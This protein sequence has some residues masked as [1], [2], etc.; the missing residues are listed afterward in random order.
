MN[1]TPEQWARL[2]RL[3]DEA[4]QLSLQSRM[5]FL[6]RVRTEKGE[7]MAEQL[8]ALLKAHDEQ[9]T[10]ADRPLVRP[11]PP[12][13]S[14][15]VKVG[16]VVLKSWLQRHSEMIETK[17]SHYHIVE[18][19]GSGGMGVVYKARD[20]RLDRFVALKFLPDDVALG[21]EVLERF[22]REARAASALNHPNICT[23]Y[24]IGEEGGRAF[25]VMEFLDGTTLKQLIDG[26]PLEVDA[27][28]RIASGLADA[29]D[30]AHSHRIIHRDIKPANIFVTGRGQAKILD[31][32]LAKLRAERALDSR[33]TTLGIDSTQSIA[34]DDGLTVAG[35]IMGTPAYMSP[36]QAC[37]EDVDARS[38]LFS[39]GAVLYEMAT[40]VRSFDGENSGAILRAVLHKDPVSPSQLNPKLPAGLDEII[41]K[42][43]AK[44]RDR[45]YTTAA[46]MEADLDRLRQTGGRLAQSAEKETPRDKRRRWTLA[47]ATVA[48]L[49]LGAAGWLYHPRPAHALSDTDTVVLADFTNSTGESV[50]DPTLQQVLETSL[51]QSPFLSVLPSQAVK[52]TLKRMG[53]PPGEQLTTDVVKEVGQRAGSKAFLAGSIARLDSQYVIVLKAVNCQT[54]ETLA[55]TRETA[56]RK[57]D[58]IV[59][60]QN[61]AKELREKLGESLASIQKVDVA[62]R[63]QQ[64]TT[65]SLEAWQSYSAARKAGFKAAASIPLYQHA[66]ELD[67][68][69]AMAHLSLGLTYL[70]LGEPDRAMESIKKAYELRSRV[71]EWE[72]YAIEGRYHASVTGDLEKARAVYEAWGATYPRRAWLNNI[73]IIDAQLG[74]YQKAVT[75]LHTVDQHIMENAN[76]A[77]NLGC[78]LA[79]SYM[80]LGLLKDARSKSEENLR[81]R[82]NSSCDHET[83]YLIA[84][85]ENDSVGMAQQ[86]AWASQ[87]GVEDFPILEEISAAYSGRLQKARE[88]SRARVAAAQAQGRPE[89]AATATAEASLREA[90]FG[91]R[92]EALQL[93]QDAL[94]L[95]RG[96]ITEYLAAVIFALEGGWEKAQ[97]LADDL[98][99]R[100]PED[101]IVRFNYLPS[102][103]A[104]IELDRRSPTNALRELETTRSYELGQAPP[105]LWPV[106]V[107]G[108]AY[109]AAHQGAEAAVE[110]QKI[111]DHRGM[112]N[113]APAGGP[114]DALAHLGLARAYS[115]QGDTAK[116]RGAYQDFFE[117]WKNADTNIRVLKEAR[118]EFNKL[119]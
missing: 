74:E 95:A 108:Q 52:A 82:P 1:P 75:L 59:A 104:L 23:I 19:L 14:S 77:A 43:L 49:I 66:I 107:R 89:T 94:T 18:K 84:F 9:T 62:W 64:V 55:Q 16:E 38:D 69:F 24:D 96:K 91:N 92:T 86:V 101:T 6:E 118:A 2:K 50:F 51:T 76:E 35:V 4:K 46:E 68:N 40:G 47:G 48:V 45:R 60:L 32:G 112:V 54:G 44:E 80:A 15:A 25:I 7:A 41:S 100:F 83:L 27:L 28:L 8:E 30:A 58:V 17:V 87:Q 73:S 13:E 103:R 115:L 12:L 85:L 53:R 78:D 109:L 31:F 20:V 67:P 102:L 21:P 70:N 119:K 56:T 106:Y 34:K 111:L 11:I 99:R 71:G 22:R 42:A 88:L 65:P 97:E 110:F 33:A 39:F 3:F 90:L 10:P 113:S 29:L 114:I 105:A 61:S 26:R 37:G 36:E 63:S 98:L 5:A 117:I 81:Y 57:E 72:R 93:A 79:G 116:A